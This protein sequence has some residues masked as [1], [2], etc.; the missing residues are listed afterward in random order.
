MMTEMK[1]KIP[2]RLKAGIEFIIKFGMMTYKCY[3]ILTYNLIGPTYL[4]FD[5]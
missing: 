5:Y 3:M 1:N 2:F 4:A